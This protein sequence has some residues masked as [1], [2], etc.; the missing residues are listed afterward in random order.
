MLTARSVDE[1]EQPILCFWKK[2]I[3][4]EKSQSL[5]MK[6]FFVFL[7]KKLC[8]N[9][10]YEM[11]NSVSCPGFLPEPELSS[12]FKDRDLFEDPPFSFSA[13]SPSLGMTPPSEP[14]SPIAAVF[15]S[16]SSMVTTVMNEHP[17]TLPPASTK[18]QVTPTKS[19]CLLKP[20]SVV[21]RPDP[22]VQGKKSENVPHYCR[23]AAANLIAHLGNDNSL[24]CEPESA[25]CEIY[26]PAGQTLW[27]VVTVC[28]INMTTYCIIKQRL[29]DQITQSRVQQH[30]FY[31]YLPVPLLE[32]M[33][34]QNVCEHGEPFLYPTV[35]ACTEIS[36][37]VRGAPLTTCHTRPA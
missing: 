35:G 4:V 8:F 17:P 5:G 31:N 22:S 15:G 30:I 19:K 21:P 9:V 13:A 24:R 23:Y 18:P 10:C 7:N 28:M 34:G 27:L 25:A 1:S 12:A 6:V 11:K 16:G 37:G 32:T 29:W 36:A 33:A 2:Y 26:P 3:V 14:P 20:A